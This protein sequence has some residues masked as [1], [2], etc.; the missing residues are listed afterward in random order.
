MPHEFKRY[1]YSCSYFEK[2]FGSAYAACVLIEMRSVLSKSRTVPAPLITI[3]SPDIIQFAI[4]NLNYSL[5][6]FQDC[7]SLSW[8]SNLY[9]LSASEY[10]GKNISWGNIWT[11]PFH[12]AKPV[13]SAFKHV[14]IP[15]TR[16]IW[17]I[18]RAG[19]YVRSCDC[20]RA[21][22]DTLAVI[23]PFG[24]VL[25]SS[26]MLAVHRTVYKNMKNKSNIGTNGKTTCS[27]W[28]VIC[29]L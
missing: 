3:T 22:R 9:L 18:Q 15:L 6:I 5:C 20:D 11:F 21:H 17:T 29:V 19:P 2:F 13:W 10:N 23:R 7:T 27:W 1:M 16:L 26:D 28:H 14:L 25:P 4:S 24:H 12:E 8:A